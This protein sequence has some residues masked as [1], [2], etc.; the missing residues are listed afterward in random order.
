MG[1]R[2]NT[3]TQS[4]A[5]QRSLGINNS[6]QKTSLEKLSSGTRITHAADDAAGLAIAEKM[7][8]GIRS[9]RQDIRNANDG[10]SMIQ[11]AEGAMSE[12]GSILVRFRELSIQAASDT[13]GDA[14]RG[15]IDKEVQQLRQEVDRIANATEY[16]GKKVLNG[17]GEV[18]EIQ[19]GM[20]NNPEQD[21]FIY[22][23]GKANITSGKLGIGELT[24]GSKQ[25]AQENLGRIDGAIKALSE[26]RAELGALQNRLQASVSNMEIYHENLSGARSRIYDVDMA[27]ETSELTK[28]NI[29]TQASTAVLSQANQ[30]NMLALKL[31]G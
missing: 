26:N 7:R 17:E 12:V 11:T 23:L 22:D 21:R 6:A 8:A 5:A 10:I 28:N 30:N 3:N 19:V 31:L 29:L 9:L 18:L 2:V 14:E 4:L 1:L 13:I 27:S 24:V 16:N 20:N 25:D 15:F